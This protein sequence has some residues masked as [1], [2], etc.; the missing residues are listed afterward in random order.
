[1]R[2]NLVITAAALFM[3][4]GITACE[5]SIQSTSQATQATDDDF[6]MLPAYPLPGETKVPGKA[7]QFDDFRLEHPDW[8]AATE[9]PPADKDFHAF[10]EW[11]PSQALLL[12]YPSAA[13]PNDTSQTIADIAVYAAPHC[14]VYIISKPAGAQV[15][16]IGHIQTGGLDQDL[17]DEKVH[18]IEI[19]ADSIW[20]ID[21]GPFP[22]VDDAG[23]I[24]F[25]DMRYYHQRAWD[26][27]I[28]ARVALEWGITDYRGQMNYE[29]GNFATDGNGLCYVSQGVFY[30]NPGTPQEE[31][32]QVFD[33]YLGCDE[34]VVLKP[35]SGEGTTHIDM[36][37][38]LVGPNK[39]ILGEYTSAQ[40][41]TNKQVLEDDA[42]ILSAVNIPG[43]G[44][45]H[46][47]RIPMPDNKDG[48]WRTFTNSTLVRPA[49]IWPVYAD[50]PELEAEALAVY[51]SVLPDWEHHAVLS[52]EII[53]W[54]GAI[55]CV[56]RQ[57]PAGPYDKWIADGTCDAGT[58]SAPEGGYDGTCKDDEDCYGPKWLCNCNDCSTGCEP[59]PDK[60]GGIS[61]EGCCAEDGSLKYC[62]NNA[63]TSVDCRSYDNCG[64]DQD[65]GWYDCGFSTEGPEE[66]PKD[67]PG[68]G[69]CGDVTEDGE[70]DGDTLKWCDE[71]ALET[72]DCTTDGMLCGED[73]EDAAKFACVCPAECEKDATQCLQD[74][75]GREVCKAGDNGCLQW[76]E[77]VC[78]EGFV[79]EDGICVEET[80][81]D[82]GTP[83]TP[84]FPDMGSPDAGT[85][86]AT[87]GDIQGDAASSDGS[88]CSAGVTRTRVWPALII[89]P[90]A[91]LIARRRSRSIMNNPG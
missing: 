11:E 51:E 52:D 56:S 27:A 43:G 10:L 59:P 33:D 23:A 65:N 24:A 45:L 49:N 74:G 91:Y 62:E 50:Y 40:D 32:F 57:I 84:V 82:P 46:F 4:I 29:G 61:F 69:E 1:M 8:Y 31:I 3:S 90:I 88:D 86:D 6:V 20:M 55:H 72:L 44:Q 37:F 12:A 66:F 5:Q 54:N 38:K 78:A 25:A 30:E 16:L 28:P 13:L 36:F 18:F 83:D 76:V 21:Y 77:E 35:L 63:I 26:D 22:L 48:V 75:T 34:M 53:K 79:C 9:P 47:A 58:C 15:D 85:T 89:F 80:T 87:T 73:P 71:G 41:S 64:W 70:C 14:H 42:D 2:S 60:C 19:E 68:E 39:A 67:C 7:D 81:P 17:I